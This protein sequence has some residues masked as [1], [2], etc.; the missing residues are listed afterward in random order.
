MLLDIGS[1]ITLS[2]ILW[3]LVIVLTRTT[4]RAK[5]EILSAAS[6]NCLTRIGYSG[7]MGTTALSDHICSAKQLLPT[8]W[9]TAL[10]QFS[11]TVFPAIGRMLR[12]G[13][14]RAS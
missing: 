4:R 11:G 7:P 6:Q 9:Q 8:C 13:W 10:R 14:I 12:G 3:R 2:R 1:A 5:S